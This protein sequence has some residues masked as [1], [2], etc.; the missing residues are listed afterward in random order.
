M[1][2][3]PEQNQTVELLI[4]RVGING[5]G[6]GYWQGYTLFVDGALPGELAKARVV[7]RKKSYGHAS[8]LSI[9]HSSP[10]RVK[11]PCSLSGTCGGCQLMHV[12]YSYQLEIKRSRVEDALKRIGKFESFPLSPCIA[13]PLPLSYRNKIQMPIRNGTNGL[14]IGFNKKNSHD[15]V[16]V[17]FCYIHCALGQHIYASVRDVLKNSTLTAF[18][19]STQQGILRHL[20]IKSAVYTDQVLVVLVTNGLAS[21]ELKA[22][23]EEIMNQCPQV[24]GVVQNVNNQADNVVLGEKFTILAGKDFIQEKLCGLQFNVSASAF[25]QVN[26]FQAEQLYEKVVEFAD[27]EGKETVL[28]A[29]C[30]VG[31][32]SLICAKQ[33]KH[34]I[35]VECVSGAI[36]DARQN[37]KNN[38]IQNVSFVCQDAEKYI[39]TLERIDVVIL[40]PPRKGCEPSLLDK[41]GK[42]LPKKIVYVS[43]DPAT[44]ARDLAHLSAFGY[45]I[46]NVQP[47]DMFPQTA[48]VENVVILHRD[49]SGTIQ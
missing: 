11:P 29:F 23:A 42:L 18:D 43:C 5:E 30:G 36:N 10:S 26:P 34:V 1:Q 22:V 41:L 20:I 31:T 37:A 47:F 48:H 33:A 14:E 7:E 35:G 17:D 12:D 49:T 28:D 15:L 46:E 16:A 21:L 40:N 25:F 38:A 3:R 13:S 4:E 2:L 32:L 6:I 45:K 8:L 39:Q 19:W 9:N 44:L 27:L 24:R